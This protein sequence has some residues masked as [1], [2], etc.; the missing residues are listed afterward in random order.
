MDLIL[1][2]AT[3]PSKTTL[4]ETGD[5]YVRFV[6]RR[7]LALTTVEADDARGVGGGS[8]ELQ[9]DRRGE[10]TPVGGLSFVPEFTGQ[11]CGILTFVQEG[12]GPWLI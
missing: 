6:G 4:T 9:G 3:Q 5:R 2:V 11:I 1:A 7:R 12:D 8:H 10:T